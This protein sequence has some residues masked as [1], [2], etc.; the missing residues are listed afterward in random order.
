MPD[1]TL[2]RWLGLA[3]LLLLAIVFGANHIA[4]RLAFDHGVTVT[5]AV[6][7]R[8]AVTALAVLPLLFM[9][10]VKSRLPRTTLGRGMLI[11]AVLAVQSYCLYSSVKLIPAALALL[12][13]NLH[14]MLL[15]L[16]S[17]ATGGE[18]PA[19]RT[20][21]AMPV[22]LFGLALALDLG[23]STGL[24]GR[25]AEIGAG[26][27]FAL[28]AG[29]SFAVAMWLTARWLQSVD[30]RLRSCLTMA[31]V[32]VLAF[33]AGAVSDT[34]A[35]PGDT[36]AWAG[37]VLLTIFYGAAITSLFMVVPRLASASDMA[38]LN[39]EPIAVL[40]I[41]WLLLGQS[42]QPLQ[43]AGALIVVATILALG[44]RR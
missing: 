34:L 11:G 24:S 19:F 28:A 17:W 3:L 2:P 5:T 14:P 27:G 37:L 22:A 1:K 39:F 32:G 13:F 6:T 16:L 42:L 38:A 26:V 23:G 4:A 25:W 9:F 40:I 44:M 29:V 8:S 31:T 18:R 43:I 35:M 10:K 36:L 15:T 33:A 30:G 20:L 21:A 7:V 12:V 41:A